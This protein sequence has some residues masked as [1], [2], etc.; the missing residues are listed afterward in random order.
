MASND[1]IRLPWH[2]VSCPA[3]GIF[4]GMLKSIHWSMIYRVDRVHC[5]LAHFRCGFAGA[6]SEKR[7]RNQTGRAHRRPSS[8]SSRK[9]AGRSCRN[10][11]WT[12]PLRL[13]ALWRSASACSWRR[14]PAPRTTSA[15]SSRETEVP[16][17]STEKKFKKRVSWLA[18][19]VS[20]SDWRTIVCFL[21]L[22]V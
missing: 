20:F 14:E 8:G 16:L 5:L 12:P 22:F 1:K 21:Y 4:F 9:Q 17:I 7:P 3:S 10:R 2:F 13:W 19:S 6:W 18:F 15:K 11:R